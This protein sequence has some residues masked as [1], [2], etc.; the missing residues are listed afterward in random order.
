MMYLMALQDITSCPFR[1][2][3]EINQVCMFN[4]CIYTVVCVIALGIASPTLIAKYETM[5]GV[6][7]NTN[8]SIM[9]A[10]S[11]AEVTQVA[12]ANMSN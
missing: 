8:F 10:F 2:V 11:K 9:L 7:V 1:V 12:L 6:I 4:S 5:Q 3:D